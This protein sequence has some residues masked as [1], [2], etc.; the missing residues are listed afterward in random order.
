LG[1]GLTPI[2]P[3]TLWCLLLIQ[4]SHTGHSCKAEVLGSLGHRN[5]AEAS[6]TLL[7]VV[8]VQAGAVSQVMR[9][10]GGAGA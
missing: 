1:E 7:P 6:P 8:E 10:G 5:W 3:T 9:L 4:D 2:L